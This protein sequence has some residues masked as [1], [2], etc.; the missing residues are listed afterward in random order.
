MKYIYLALSFI[1]SF[2]KANGQ[3]S[4]PYFIESSDVVSQYAPDHI[5]REILQDRKGNFWL[6]TW[7]GIVKYDGRV[8]TNYTVKE[9]LIRFHVVCCYEDSKGNLWFGTARGGVYRYNGEQ[10]T[11]FT[12]L[13]GLIDNNVADI[14]EDKAGNVW[15]G[16]EHGASCYNG[17]SFTNFKAIDGLTD[18]FVN[19]I[20][21]D[22][23]GK[24]WFGCT[25]GL[26]SFDGSSFTKKKDV[27]FTRITGL[28]EDR[29][30]NFWVA[31]F[32]GL[33]RYDESK[34]KYRRFLTEHLTYYIIEDKAGNILLSH[35]E[36]NPKY[37][38]IPTQVLY[39]FNAGSFSRIAEKG[40]QNDF[41]VFGKMVDKDNNIW[42][43]TMHGPC[44]YDGKTFKY[45]TKESR[46]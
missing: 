20:M 19:C 30:G 21:Q 24:L 28:L 38:N 39:K 14:I 23:S 37:S 9:N 29:K 6:A 22:R 7:M 31:S 40:E 45:F 17:K 33:I 18:D 11:L 12:R 26:F 27:P 32:D 44:K 35:S 46:S 3:A 25:D 36:S 13:D 8:F 16:T 4:D 5:T 1:L 10:F 42:F 43:G 15:F 34:T 2:A 41:Q